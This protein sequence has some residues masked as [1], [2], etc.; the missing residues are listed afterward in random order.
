KIRECFFAFRFTPAMI[1]EFDGNDRFFPITYKEHW[2]VV[3]DIAEKTG[4][5][6][7][8]SA[9]EVEA[10]REDEALTKKPQTPAKP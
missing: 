9:Y 8:R 6:F 1:K 3:R 2:A 5:P 7:N 4:T 10:K